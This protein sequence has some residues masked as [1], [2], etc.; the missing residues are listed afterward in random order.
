M[1]A[2]WS[3]YSDEFGYRSEKIGMVDAVERFE[4]AY[5]LVQMFD[6]ENRVVLGRLMNGLRIPIPDEW[7]DILF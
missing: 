4:D 3:K 1:R 5:F 2:I 6:C 7:A